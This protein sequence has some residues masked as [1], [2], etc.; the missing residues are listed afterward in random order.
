MKLQ[1]ELEHLM[2]LLQAP[3]TYKAFVELTKIKEL[4]GVPSAKEM[5][6]VLKQ[7]NET[8][9]NTCRDVLKVADAGD[10]E[11]SLSLASDRMR[12]HERNAWMLNTTSK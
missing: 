9:V 10:D 5:I 7:N 8:I 1:R 12:I 4:E 2:L 6:L 3:G 11:S